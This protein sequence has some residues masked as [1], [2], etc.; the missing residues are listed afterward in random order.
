MKGYPS[1]HPSRRAAMEATLQNSIGRL[2]RI[3]DFS[4]LL[5]GA[6]EVIAYTEN[7]TDLLRSLCELAVR[8]THLRRGHPV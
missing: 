6:N 8:H 4:V 5:S 2:Q 1:W 3:T 7:E